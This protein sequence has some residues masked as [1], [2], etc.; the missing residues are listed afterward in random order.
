[1]RVLVANIP[2]P[3]NRFLVDLHAA[4]A[5]MCEVTHSSDA[6]WRMDG[7]FDVVH[8]HF[9]EYLTYDVESSYVNGLNQEMIDSVAERL[10]WWSGRAAIIVTRHVLLPHD[11]RHDAMW[12]KMYE[13][14]YSYA[15]GVVHFANASVE[16]FRDRYRNTTFKRGRQP[17][18]AVIPHHNYAS[19]PNVVGR[20]EAR[21]R[22]G[23][24]LDARVMLV[25]GAIRGEAER[26]LILDAFDGLPTAKKLLLVS[27][28]R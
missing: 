26:Q 2:L 5:G 18:H 11:A 15:D 16:E 22:L 25:F 17:D 23:I 13:M 24:P 3:Q 7:D 9:P 10:A 20:E 8:L 21:K 1:M 6:F 4:L 28:W 14:V 27:R 19:L 12:E